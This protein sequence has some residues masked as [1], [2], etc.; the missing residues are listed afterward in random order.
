[1][2]LIL[3]TY[4]PSGVKHYPRVHIFI[5]TAYAVHVHAE[6]RKTLNQSTYI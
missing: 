2:Q 4:M 6:W 1:M 3:Y 5:V